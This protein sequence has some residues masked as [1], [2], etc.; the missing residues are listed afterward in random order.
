[1]PPPPRP[2]VPEDLKPQASPHEIRAFDE[3]ARERGEAERES[4]SNILI[5]LV[6]QAIE[7]YHRLEKA[8]SSGGKTIPHILMD[9]YGSTVEMLKS[10]KSRL[11]KAIPWDSSVGY[12]SMLNAP[13][14]P[15][16]TGRLHV[17]MLSFS[18]SSFH[19]NGMYGSDVL[20][21]LLLMRGNGMG[22]TLD[23]TPH[24]ADL[25]LFGWGYDGSISNSAFGLAMTLLA[26][27]CMLS[28]ER[29][30]AA[31]AAAASATDEAA[32]ASGECQTKLSNSIVAQLGSIR[33]KSALRRYFSNGAEEREAGRACV[34]GVPL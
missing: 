22:H 31:S 14:K 20:D 32:S 19:A 2:T 10:T 1:M 30:A 24:S 34:P 12:V 15:R 11:L 18:P 21:A 26:L 27:S 16:M 28:H 8:A 13:T 3:A 9:E 29:S 17:A 5:A 33:G 6:W 4:E 25:S 7:L 23:V